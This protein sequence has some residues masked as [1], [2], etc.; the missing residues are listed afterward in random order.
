VCVCGGGGG[1]LCIIHMY[2]IHLGGVE[3]HGRQGGGVL[4]QQG[5]SIH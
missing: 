3:Q 2:N 5:C 4:L 1:M